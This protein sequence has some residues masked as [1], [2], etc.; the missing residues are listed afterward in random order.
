MV[1]GGARGLG[2]GA[3]DRLA[4]DGDVVVVLDVSE[5]VGIPPVRIGELDPALPQQS[6]RVDVSD[7][8]A[9]RA[10]IDAVVKELGGIDVLVVGAGVA[11]PAQPL[12]DVDSTALDRIL[13]VNV[14]GVVATLQAAL[15]HMTAARSGCIVVIS[16]QTGKQAWAGW[17]VYSGSKAFAVSLVQAVAL[18][19][20]GDG[21]RINALCPGTME[22]DM[23]RTAFAARAAASGRALEDEIASYASGIPVGRIGD[24][25]DVGA[26]VAWLT[27]AE[28][29]FVTGTALNLTGGEMVF[30]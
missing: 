16:S 20:A 1:T 26:A 4:A 29:S 10:A 2:R 19:H 3:A 25:G 18:E 8:P 13:A 11:I 7:A 15:V 5:P 27:S 22:S 17:G 6:L 30:F 12:R 21:I 28:S 14:R 23:M 9:V 24:A